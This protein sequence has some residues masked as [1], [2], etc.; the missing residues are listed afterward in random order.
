[1]GRST[2]AGPCPLSDPTGPRPKE[3][4]AA[5]TTAVAGGGRELLDME[6]PF[7]PAPRGLPKRGAQGSHSD[8]P[9]SGM[10]LVVSIW[11]YILVHLGIESSLL[12]A[13]N[14][15][16]VTSVSY[17]YNDWLPA[18]RLKKKKYWIKR[19][20]H[21]LGPAKLKFFLSPFALITSEIRQI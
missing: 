19:A 8:S 15:L 1:M 6:P 9:P 20:L 11:S 14:F 2:H 3:A 18:S 4:A 10:A 7:H 12:W 13:V 21:G 17:F 5:V 16:Y